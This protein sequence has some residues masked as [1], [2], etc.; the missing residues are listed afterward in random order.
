MGYY[1]QTSQPC[2][3][4]AEICEK[5]GGIPIPHAPLHFEDI[6]E[7]KALICVVDNGP[8]EAAGFCYD[9]PEFLAFTD[10]ND[11]RYKEYLLLDRSVA[12]KLTGYRHG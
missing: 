4:A 10:I 9:N 2:G 5:H 12:E 6:P 1:I 11:Y 3:K 8:F 7:G